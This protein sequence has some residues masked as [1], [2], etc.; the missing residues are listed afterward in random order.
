VKAAAAAAAPETNPRRE[1]SREV[2][3][4]RFLKSY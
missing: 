3:M 1:T 4:D 2:F